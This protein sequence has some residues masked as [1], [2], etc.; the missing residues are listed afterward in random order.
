MSNNTDNRMDKQETA[1]SRQKKKL[2]S[3]NPLT[4]KNI[5]QMD[6]RKD[7]SNFS[8]PSILLPDSTEVMIKDQPEFDCLGEQ[9]NASHVEALARIL[10]E[11]GHRVHHA[12]E[13]VAIS[14]I[15]N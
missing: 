3:A 13:G 4:R 5:S 10:Q 11:H 6:G 15:F 8:S 2:H 1:W 7:I 14:I 9:G 12:G